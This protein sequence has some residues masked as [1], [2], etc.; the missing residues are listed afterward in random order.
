MDERWC[1]VA[2]SLEDGPRPAP[3]SAFPEDASPYGLRGLAGNVGEFC[4]NAPESGDAVHRIVRGGDF[5][6]APPAA[7]L[8]ARTEASLR[9]VSDTCG[10][11]LAVPIRAA[12]RR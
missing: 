1:N 3:V 11:R 6:D 12:E 10:F 8:S 9:L 4:L 5:T 2:R 7:R